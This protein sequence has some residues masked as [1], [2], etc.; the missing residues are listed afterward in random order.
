MTI[1]EQPT[2]PGLVRSP[3]V[4]QTR[5]DTGSGPNLRIR[6]G[7]Y[8]W[9]GVI[10]D[11]PGAANFVLEKY[12][13]DANQAVWDFSQIVKSYMDNQ[14]VWTLKNGPSTQSE[15]E[16]WMVQVF[17]L[18]VSDTG[19]MPVP[20][21]SN[22]IMTINGAYD[23]KNGVNQLTVPIRPARR[24]R[25]PDSTPYI[26]PAFT[27]IY[28]LFILRDDQNNGYLIDLR[29]FNPDK[30]NEY[31]FHLATGSNK[32][33]TYGLAPQKEYYLFGVP[34]G[35]SI[36]QKLMTFELFCEPKYTPITVAFLDQ[37]GQWDF[38]TFWKR[39]DSSHNRTEERYMNNYLYPYGNT[40]A[41]QF[42]DEEKGQF[43]QFMVNSRET[44]RLN[45]GSIPQEEVE[46]LY[47]MTLSERLMAYD[48]IYWNPLQLETNPFEY[49]KGINEQGEM[50]YTFEFKVGNQA[51]NTAA[52]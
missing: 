13:N 48:G 51:I 26:Y 41:N 36:E 21:E 2:T 37:L 29:S 30:T 34:T 1:L 5:I 24:V 28:N 16:V 27:A 46:T 45:T 18:W 39:S 10:G 20:V 25:I 14:P 35:G 3:L 6:A 47:Q 50:S 11:R 15:D 12:P 8:I 52:I 32:F 42:Y 38:Y 17:F 49:K 22:A 40:P 43:R 19:S 44:L 9:K 31:L 23:Y 33:G 7:L 4:Y